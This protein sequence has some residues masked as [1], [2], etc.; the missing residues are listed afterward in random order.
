MMIPNVPDFYGDI[1]RWFIGVVKNV[2][3]PLKLGR[4]RVR[5]RGIHDS[6]EIKDY[7]LP[8]AQVLVPTT[9][10]GSSGLGT[11]PN[12][13][14]QAQVFG[15]FLDG[16]N[17]QLPLILGSI[18]K[19]ERNPEAVGENL[20]QNDRVLPGESNEEKAFLYLI[21]DE[22]H[23]YT[24]K[25]AAGIVGNLIHESGV[26]PTVTSKV[27]GEKSFGI[28]QWNPAEAAGNRLQKLI[29]YCNVN[30]LNS[31]SLYGQLV[32]LKHEIEEYKY[33]RERPDIGNI[34]TAATVRDASIT[35]E[36]L[37]ERPQSGST[38][39][40]IQKAEQVFKRFST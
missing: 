12:L 1:T 9:E 2:N 6:I 24:E 34:K 27:P 17:S 40:R 15:L 37:Y 26:D 23:S 18:P 25:Q 13:R 20:Y 4:V 11:T 28:A 5:I 32:Y 19:F 22:I 16:K 10:D 39:I 36:K 7:E 33:L 29:E 3:D 31:N 35:F 30:R 38:D 21:S 14:E 8:W